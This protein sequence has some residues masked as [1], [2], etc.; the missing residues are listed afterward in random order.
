MTR[1]YHPLVKRLLDALRPAEGG[2]TFEIEEGRAF[3]R[4]AQAL[5]STDEV[6][7][8]LLVLVRF[9]AQ[10]KAQATSYLF[11]ALA[12]C[13]VGELAVTKALVEL[14]SQSQEAVALVKGGARAELDQRFGIGAKPKTT[15]MS[16]R[17]R[18]V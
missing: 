3:L 1:A 17:R 8:E 5:P 6:A 4:A 15:G 11:T 18:G 2:P 10:R 7:A 13:L 14:G 16:L 12:L 9:F